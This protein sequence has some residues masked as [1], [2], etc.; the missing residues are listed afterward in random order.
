MGLLEVHGVSKGF[1]EG[2]SRHE[3]LRDVHLSVREGEFLAIVGFSGSGKSTLLSL[4][5]GLT[6]PDSGKIELA[7]Q[8]IVDTGRDRGI[9]FQTYSLL[10]WLTVYG[11]IRLAVDEV[12][13]EWTEQQRHEHVEKYIALVNLSHAHDRRPHELSGG[14]KQRT[15][16]ARALAMSPK[17]LLLDEPFGALDALTRGTLQTELERI[18]Q[19]D[20]K[21]VVMIT[22]DVDEALLLADRIVPLTAR[23][24]LGEP[25]TVD[26][27]RPREHTELN[28]D[29]KFKRLRLEVTEGLIAV[30]DHH[31]EEHGEVAPLPDV[32]PDHLIGKKVRTLFGLGPSRFVKAGGQR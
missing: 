32:R 20:R 23:G 1:G 14:M 2:P 18:W 17:I 27:D 25:I 11:N 28:H 5:A 19:A 24:T 22:N 15:A 31:E 3:V 16:V 21:T 9:V 12:Y 6:R 8:E 13:P 7:G 29:P 10:P 30:V 4:L 26:L